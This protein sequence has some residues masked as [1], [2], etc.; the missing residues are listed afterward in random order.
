MSARVEVFTGPT[1][2]STLLPDDGEATISAWAEATESGQ[3]KVIPFVDR[4]T[5]GAT[6]ISTARIDKIVV[7]R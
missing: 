5:G 2:F 3:H 4:A 1:G 6:Y 7:T